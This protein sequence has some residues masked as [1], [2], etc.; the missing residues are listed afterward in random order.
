MQVPGV[1]SVPTWTELS[2]PCCA[3]IQRPVTAVRQK[4]VA[5]PVKPAG[6]ITYG[7]PATVEIDASYFVARAAS[8]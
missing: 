1:K 4:S 5:D 8:Q 2:G 3:A 7:A 6:L